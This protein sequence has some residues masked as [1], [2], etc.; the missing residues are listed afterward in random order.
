MIRFT[1]KLK[2]REHSIKLIDSRIKAELL[3]RNY[4]LK[5]NFTLE[6]VL[7]GTILANALQNWS[8]AKGTK[9]IHE[10]ADIIQI[11]KDFFPKKKI[12]IKLEKYRKVTITFNLDTSIRDPFT[13]LNFTNVIV[14]AMSPTFDETK[15]YVN[16]AVC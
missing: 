3:K 6:V 15:V 2:S 8:L 13:F 10:I 4:K 11:I 9:G 1:K 14:T 12:E 16:E 5:N 7:E